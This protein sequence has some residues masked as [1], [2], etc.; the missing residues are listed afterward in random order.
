MDIVTRVRGLLLDPRAEW[1]AIDAE[2]SSVDSLY[3]DYLVF[4]AGV[5]ALAGFIGMSLVG[6]ALPVIGTYRVPL[7]SGI[8]WALLTFGLSL[9]GVY[10][11][12]LIVDRLAPGFGGTPNFINAFKL[13][14]YSATAAWLAG[15]FS[16]IPA[17]GVLG[18]LG[19]Y[20]LYLFYTGLPVL[21]RAPRERVFVYAVA[22]ILAGILV[23]VAVLI[24]VSVLTGWL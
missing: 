3:R 16:I 14:G 1:L 13:S 18:L 5:P 24:I 19:L 11:L 21:M 9:G 10:V 2:P 12:A 7:F 17:L 4:L 15:I 23:N 20:S 22:T 8:V 6:H